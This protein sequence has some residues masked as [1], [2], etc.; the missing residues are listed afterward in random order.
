MWCS[1]GVVLL[2]TLS[3]FG[4]CCL[5]FPS[6][7]GA[8]F[9]IWWCSLASSPFFGW[10]GFPSSPL[11][12]AV[13][14]PLFFL[15]V[16]LL[17]LLL[18]GGVICICVSVSLC[19]CVRMSVSVWVCLS[20]PPPVWG[21]PSFTFVS[22]CSPS[23]LRLRVRTSCDQR[24]ARRSVVLRPAPS[25]TSVVVS[26]FDEAPSSPVDVRLFPASKAVPSLSPSLHLSV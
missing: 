7:G 12:G 24:F 19:V 2:F 11:G 17:S 18:L 25:H 23:L 4:W 15:V 21:S 16:V 8:A 26:L 3:A 1:F 22:E 5:A 20:S 14:L 10:C 6:S 9:H 13:F